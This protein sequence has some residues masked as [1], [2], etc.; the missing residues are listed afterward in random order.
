SNPANQI[1]ISFIG[2]KTFLT[3]PINGRREI[4][5]SLEASMNQLQEVSVVAR[6]EAPVSDL[7]VAARNSTRATS[8][9]NA[10]KIDQLSVGSIDQ[11]LQG[12]L[13]GVDFGAT[14]GDPGAG[15]SIRIRGTSSING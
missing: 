1:S 12:R 4:N 11:A 10:E 9:I 3:G 13:T 2:Y 6:H 8:T 5:I 14:S 7:P 15:M